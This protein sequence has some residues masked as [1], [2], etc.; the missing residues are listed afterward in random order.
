[1]IVRVESYGSLMERD[2]NGNVHCA[3]TAAA[4]ASITLMT[5]ITTKYLHVS[6]LG[7]FGGRAFVLTYFRS[8]K[9]AEDRGQPIIF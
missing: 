3:S 6:I 1:M 4:L 8:F 2:G 7:A 5:K 9:A